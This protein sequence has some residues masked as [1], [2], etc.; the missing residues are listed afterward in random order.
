LKTFRLL[1]SVA[2]MYHIEEL[3]AEVFGIAMSFW[4]S[5]GWEEPG[6]EEP[7]PWVPPRPSVEPCQVGSKKFKVSLV[8]QTSS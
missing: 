4:M 7:P 3:M 2:Q 8:S 1:L 5:N 6:P